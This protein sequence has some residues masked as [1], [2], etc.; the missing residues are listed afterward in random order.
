[1]LEKLNQSTLAAINVTLV[2]I[3]L[4]SSAASADDDLSC[5]QLL[6]SEKQL[7]EEIQTSLREANQAELYS[8]LTGDLAA[9][10]KAQL[11][12]AIS[13]KLITE[14]TETRSQIK[15]QACE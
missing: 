3:N 12:D 4:F 13:E 15:K 11:N 8:L 5:A 7:T 2:A 10:D 6:A 14:L 9:A 1:M